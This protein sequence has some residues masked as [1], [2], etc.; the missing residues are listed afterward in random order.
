VHFKWLV[1]YIEIIIWN[2]IMFYFTYAFVSFGICYCMQNLELNIIL[3]ENLS[4]S[5]YK[6]TVRQ[7]VSL[8][9]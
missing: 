1:K 4:H 3:V 8:L 5:L 6:T 2:L 7:R 9:L